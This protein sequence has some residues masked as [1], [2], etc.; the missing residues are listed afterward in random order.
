M[1]DLFYIKRFLSFLHK[2]SQIVLTYLYVMVDILNIIKVASICMKY[3]VFGP[4]HSRGDRIIFVDIKAP[5]KNSEA[6]RRLIRLI[7]LIYWR[8]DDSREAVYKRSKKQK[9]D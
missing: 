7:D 1:L 9:H 8:Q 6:L 2:L 3:A 4:T 5:K